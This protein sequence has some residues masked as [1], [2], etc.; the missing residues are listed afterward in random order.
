MLI[1][2]LRVHLRPYRRAIYLLLVLQAIQALLNLYLPNLNASLIDNGVLTDNTRYIWRIGGWMLVVAMVQA[3]FALWAIYLGSRIAMSF[4]RDVRRE[5]FKRSLELSAREVNQLGAPS[6]ITRVT[7]D[8]QQV[9][10]LVVMTATMVLAAPITV[11]GGVILALRQ[12]V[13]H[14]LDPVRQHA[15]PGDSHGHPDR[16]SGP[17]VQAHAG[18]LGPSQPG[19]AGADHG[20]PGDPGIR[21]R[22]PGD[23]PLLQRE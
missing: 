22:T 4:G 11:V 6:L 19:A 20:D 9:Q 2:L 8:V 17:A 10:L 3:L 5:V 15:D 18:A 7:N 1:R 14:R 12:N 21:P 13:D 16:P 23:G